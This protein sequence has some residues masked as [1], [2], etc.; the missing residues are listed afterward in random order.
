MTRQDAL[1]T[2]WKRL[3]V[4]LCLSLLVCVVV[5]FTAGLARVAVMVFLIGNI[6]GY[7]SVHRGLSELRDEEVIGLASS[8]WSIVVPSFVGGV[9]ALAMYLL[10][11]SNILGGDLF[12][13]EERRVGKE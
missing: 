8:W 6:G 12:R 3:L 1:N 2:I 4:V 11:L 7:V 13:S 10:F 5:L 9:L